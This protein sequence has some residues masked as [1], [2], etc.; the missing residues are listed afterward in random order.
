V[1]WSYGQHLRVNRGLYWH[2][3]VSVGD[4][5]VIHFTGAASR[6]ADATIRY[7]SVEAFAAGGR[8]QMVNY[9]RRY[10]PAQ[11]VQ[12]ALSRLGQSGYHAF[13]NNC[14]HFARWCMTGEHRSAE[15]E[16]KTASTAGVAS[17]TAL[18]S[19]ATAGATAIGEAAGTAG[20]AALMNGLKVMGFG[21]GVPVG[22]V[23]AAAVPTVA[24]N[25]AIRKA[26]PDDPNLPDGE[27]A[28]RKAARDTAT[29]AGI[30]GTAGSIG[31][32]ALAGTPG[33]SAVGISTGL[34]EL[35][36][37]VGGGMVAG[38]AV[39]MALPALLVI[40]LGLLVYHSKQKR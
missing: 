26:L 16:R 1:Q 31:L 34:A 12:N 32:V 9:K 22:L 19:A 29:V 35:G 14:E 10:S 37:L 2:H 27:R 25:Y 21:A 6:K 17:G 15:A 4:R 7:D 18:A 8:V 33:L 39:T 5:R 38:T 20:S 3:A 40:G 13:G 23:T 11:V 30:A 36:G 24:A 28:A